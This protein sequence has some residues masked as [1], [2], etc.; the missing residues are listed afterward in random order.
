[1]FVLHDSQIHILEQ[2]FLL[3]LFLDELVLF[4]GYILV[5][6]REKHFLANTVVNSQKFVVLIHSLFVLYNFEFGTVVSSSSVNLTCIHIHSSFAQIHFLDSDRWG[7]RYKALVYSTP[8]RGHP[9]N[10]RDQNLA[11]ILS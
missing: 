11:Y 6:S 2:S 10:F 9:C 5:R 1:M 7:G 3:R 8:K 4:V